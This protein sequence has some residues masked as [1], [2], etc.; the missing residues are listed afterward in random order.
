MY[1][2]LQKIYRE[3]VCRTKIFR[4]KLE[5]YPFHSKKL[6]APTPMSAPLSRGCSQDLLRQ[7]FMEHSGHMSEPT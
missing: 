2:Q 5:K 4:A 3:K 7:S 1:Q 6:P